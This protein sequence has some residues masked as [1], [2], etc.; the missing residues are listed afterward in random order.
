MLRLVSLKPVAES[1][2]H[3]PSAQPGSRLVAVELPVNATPLVD[4][5]WLI[6]RR[7]SYAC[8]YC[9]PHRHDPK[10]AQVDA[11]S[12]VAG[13]GTLCGLL[14]G[15][16]F[17]LNLTGGEPTVHPGFLRFIEA[18]CL[19]SQVAAV[20]VVTNLASPDRLYARLAEIAAVRP[21]TLRVVASLHNGQAEPAAFVRRIQLLVAAHVST[22]VKV[23]LDGSAVSRS[24][25]DELGV[26]AST[27]A[28]LS[29]G[30]QAVRGQIADPMAD[31]SNFSTPS[32]PSDLRRIIRD[33]VGGGSESV[34]EVAGIIERGENHFLGWEC[35]VGS[36]ALLV[37]SDGRVYSALCKP[38]PKP[39]FNLYAHDPDHAAQLRRPTSVL[40]PY[41]TCECSSSV[42]IPKRRSIGNPH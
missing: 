19:C 36:R 8:S 5:H 2:T 6:T 38:E 3:A 25:V 29:I 13:L 17:R 22:Y 28:C 9:P 20:R 1:L 31:L 24:A 39:I 27:N 37:E 33:G 10:A 7:C 16:Q 26:L 15:E 42:R 35:E 4:V 32:D 23:M 14:A 21:D 11:V 34:D 18:A 30:T 41:V 12:L 40:C